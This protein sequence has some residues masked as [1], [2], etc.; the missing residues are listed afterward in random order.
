MGVSTDGQ[1]TFGIDLGE[2]LP[3]KIREL[4]DDDGFDFDEFIYRDVGVEG[5]WSR[6]MS[7]EEKSDYFA[8]RKTARDEYPVQLIIHCSY[9]YPMYIIAPNVKQATRRNNRG[10]PVEIN[11]DD[12]KVSTRA[13][14]AFMA[15][16]GKWGIEGEP[17]WWLSSLWG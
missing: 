4:I 12:L 17:R 11:P 6:D 1:L 10:Y 2:E 14:A 15:W 5:S 9:D 13:Y 3:E 7:D 16:C 8:R